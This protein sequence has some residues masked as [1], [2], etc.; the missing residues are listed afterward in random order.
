MR[1]WIF[2]A[3]IAA[4]TAAAFFFGSIFLANGG[5]DFKL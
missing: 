1:R 4:A 3:L 2:V 5:I